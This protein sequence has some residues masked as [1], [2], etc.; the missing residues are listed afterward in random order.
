MTH[1]QAYDGYY[2]SRPRGSFVATVIVVAIL[3]LL[4]SSTIQA[5]ESPVL[6]QGEMQRGWV[7]CWQE[8]TRHRGSGRIMWDYA[9]VECVR[10]GR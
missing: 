6:P 4:V 1:S 10:V 8:A 2:E 3:V 9:N 5:D 7:E